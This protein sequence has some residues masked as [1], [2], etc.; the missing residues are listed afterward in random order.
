[1]TDFNEIIDSLVK[2]DEQRLLQLLTD[3]LDKGIPADDI[4]NNGL[5]AGM[6]IVGEKMENEDM[7]IPEVLM[8][9]QTMA[10]GVEILKPLIGS[11]GVSSVGS[12]VIGTVKGDLH[13]IGKNLV[14]MM[15]RA[16]G[17]KVYDLGVDVEPRDFIDKAKEVDADLIGMSLIMSICLD[18]MEKVCRMLKENGVRAKTIVGGPA[19]SE[20][21]AK[22]IGADAYGGF[23]AVTGVHTAKRMLGI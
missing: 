1:M 20:R 5:I 23:D 17:F 18:Q 21:V 13:D 7:F 8:A 14:A 3:S 16:G 19:T 9:A 15:M 12:V 4:L 6:D 22:Q 11:E 10:K 2:L